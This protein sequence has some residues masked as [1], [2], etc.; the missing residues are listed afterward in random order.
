MK[1]TNKGR[2]LQKEIESI[3]KEFKKR[4]EIY[5]FG[6]GTYGEELRN[7]LEKYDVF[8]GYIDNDVEKQGCGYNGAKVIP[9][10]KSTDIIK[11]KWIVVAGSEK[12]EAAISAQLE[13]AGLCNEK[14]FFLHDFFI[15]KI[16]P[17]ISLYCFDKLY[18]DLAQISLTERCTLKCKKCA[19]ACFNVANDEEDMPLS[20]VKESADCFFSRYDMV[21][22]FVLIGGEPFLY[23]DIK[24]AVEYI[25]MN[26]RKKMII[27]S[28]TTNGTIVPDDE[29]I[30]LCKKYGVTFRVSDYSDSIPQLEKQYKKLYEK[31]SSSKVIVWKTNKEKSWFDY[32]FDGFDRGDIGENLVDVFD[33]CSTQCREIRGSKYYYCVMARSVADNLGMDIGRQDYIDLEAIQDRNILLEFQMGFSDKGYLD[34]CRYCRGAE[35][36]NYLIPAA[37]Q[38][39]NNI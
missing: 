5:I 29:M 37:E 13:K 38:K 16:F 6:A 22:E 39:R 7:V 1:W 18:V 21:R 36:K 11:E 10:G 2:E 3:L 33:K 25:A 34:M 4:K 9:F 8:A 24:D 19:H 23:K 14:D 35:A 15:R 20:L 17:I 30:I 32:G 26:Y 27:F 28:I 12:N 31:L